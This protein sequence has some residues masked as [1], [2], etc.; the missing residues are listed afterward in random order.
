VKT[1]N[2]AESKNLVIDSIPTLPN[3]TKLQLK[4]CGLLNFGIKRWADRFPKLSELDCRCNNV[5]TANP[6]PLLPELK[7]LCLRDTGVSLL[8]LR[9]WKQVPKLEA[10]DLSEN[11]KLEIETLPPLPFLK[12]LTIQKHTARSINDQSTSFRVPNDW[13]HCFYGLRTLVLDFNPVNVDLIP[14][15][16]ILNMLS[17]D[18]CNLNDLGA[19]AATLKERLPSLQVLCLT[20]NPIDILHLTPLPLLQELA[21]DYTDQTSV[22]LYPDTWFSMFP[23]LSILGL[24]GNPCLFELTQLN[25]SISR[26]ELRILRLGCTGDENGL[27]LAPEV[28]DLV[29]IR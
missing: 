18:G 13:S 16:P 28:L 27:T 6:F 26:G 14:H 22:D 15:F 29:D 2:L 4:N 11:P 20:R 5:L 7:V 19:D 1:L 24:S 21:L 23:A 25:E 8:Q 12:K 17:L 3:L 9:F 10:L